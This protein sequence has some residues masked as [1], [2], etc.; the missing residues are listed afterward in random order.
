M[1]TAAG[2]LVP[3]PCAAFNNV[4]NGLCA[5]EDKGLLVYPG[6][7][8]GSHRSPGLC[9]QAC[10]DDSWCNAYTSLRPGNGDHGKCRKFG[11][12][13]A[14]SGKCKGDSF[15]FYRGNRNT[16]ACNAATVFTGGRG[17][18]QDR[19]RY[20]CNQKKIAGLCHL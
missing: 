1:L 11:A 9:K 13:Y 8:Y 4:G 5:V 6:H 20:Y 18:D 12:A 3:R 16:P 14:T 17:T 10:A 19:A 15:T 2:T 7:C